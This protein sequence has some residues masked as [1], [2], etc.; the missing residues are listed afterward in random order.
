MHSTVAG[1]LWQQPHLFH[2][3]D[4]LVEVLLQL[5]VGQVDAEL[6]KVVF[7]EALKAVNVQHANQRWGC[8]VLQTEGVFAG[9]AS[10][11]CDLA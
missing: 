9:A 4:V 11:S 6:L 7:L 3:E 5:L 2:L 8:G 1:E 10:C